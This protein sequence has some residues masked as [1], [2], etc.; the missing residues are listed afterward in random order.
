MIKRG[1]ADIMVAGGAEAAV[2]KLGVAGFCA[3]RS[4][5]TNFNEKPKEASRPWDKDRDGFVI[6]EGSGILV[7]EDYENAKK[8]GA[9][10]YAELSGY[11]MSGD[12]HHITSPSEDG[13]G[14]YRA[15][16][17]AIKMASIN[18]DDIDYINAHGTS[19]QIGDDIELNAIMRFTNN[20]KKLKI[21]S[22]KSSIGH[23]LGA[24][25]SVEAI[26]SILTINNKIIPATLNLD[27]PSHFYEVDLVPKHSIDYNVNI[28][29]SNSFGFG[30]TNT[31]LLFNSI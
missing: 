11:G 7:L 23:L 20:N 24:A 15:M 21:S 22:T 29:L 17:E 13:E 31:A 26:F 27:N 28:V 16:Q 2:C 12:A 14:G 8:R 30:G 3:A 10:I 9:K 25:G 18:S 19:T 5:S 1:A 6:G 4:L